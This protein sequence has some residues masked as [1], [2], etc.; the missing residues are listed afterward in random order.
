MEAMV[1]GFVFVVVVVAVVV[2]A[3]YAM[4]RTSLSDLFA[5]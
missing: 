4:S 3:A 1:V 5:S 2:V